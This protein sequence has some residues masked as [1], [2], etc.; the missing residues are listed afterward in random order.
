ML[1]QALILHLFLFHTNESQ[2][3]KY[4]CEDVLRFLRAHDENVQDKHLNEVMSSI[5]GRESDLIAREGTE[6]S[7]NKSKS[8]RT[9]GSGPQCKICNRTGH[10][11]DE[12]KS[13]CRF[14]KKTGHKKR[15]CPE[16]PDKK[17]TDP[18]PKPKRNLLLA[19]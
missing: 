10:K 7:K 12:C 5:K 19:P 15:D 13:P 4:I 16:K 3:T 17:R 11:T 6:K 9:E 18:G 1:P 2:K 14:C 8:F